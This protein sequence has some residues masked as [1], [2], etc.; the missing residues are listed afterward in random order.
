VGSLARCWRWPSPREATPL[1]RSGTGHDGPRRGTEQGQFR[2]GQSEG[3]CLMLRHELERC[4]EQQGAAQ[5][6]QRLVLRIQFVH[7]PSVRF[8]PHAT[9]E[10]REGSG[11]LPRRAVT[12]AVMA[13]VTA[14][15][16]LTAARARSFD[17]S[18]PQLTRWHRA[19]LLGRPEQ[20]SLGRGRG[21][22][23]VYPEGSAEQLV[24]LCELHQRHRRLDHVVWLLYWDRFDVSTDRVRGVVHEVVAAW[25][26][27][28][29]Q[30]YKDNGDLT[31]AAEDFLDEAHA[32]R[33]PSKQLRW[34]RRRVGTDE[35]PVVFEAVMRAA[36]GHPIGE[37]LIEQVEFAMGLD[38]AR[39]ESL[40][41]TPPW[42]EGDPQ[43]GIREAGALMRPE[44][45]LKAA[46]TMSDSDLRAAADRA[47]GMVEV[48][49]HVG[50]LIGGTLGRWALGFGLMGAI[51]SDVE[52]DVTGQ[53]LMC[54]FCH[55]IALTD[56]GGNFEAV[57]GTLPQLHEAVIAF[58]CS[59]PSRRR[60]RRLA[61]L[62]AASGWRRRCA[63]KPQVKPWPR[64]YETCA[65]VTTPRSRGF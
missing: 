52:E 54:R 30:A 64:R 60:S 5:H 6:N 28:W 57:L 16:L 24:R 9:H 29:A 36:A 45:M 23:T 44:V 26:A 32:R 40:P 13:G 18:R 38:R 62:W 21:T 17:V 34:M 53:I 51:A 55:S 41:G 4:P 27:S 15:D 43:D 50:E 7:L 12:C 19:G 48:F 59:M 42:L 10:H 3:H 20:R 14:D 2:A 25:A 31:E 65:S 1:G 35:F 61:P 11:P 39:S 46:H 8:E 49:G 33:L 37:P 47:R 63:T 56:L 22:E 58:Q